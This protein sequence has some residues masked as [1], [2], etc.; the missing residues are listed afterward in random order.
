MNTNTQQPTSSEDLSLN[1]AEHALDWPLEFW[2]ES[3]L[4][5]EDTKFSVMDEACASALGQQ[6]LSVKRDQRL[7]LHQISRGFGVTSV[8][9]AESACAKFQVR[10]AAGGGVYRREVGS[11]VS[12][13]SCAG[14]GG[15]GRSGCVLRA[16][17]G[18]VYVCCKGDLL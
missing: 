4:G 3:D 9:L 8:Q 16:T 13:F 17:S 1:L 7:D 15:L 2:P 12:Y 14:F 11:G 10:K 5:I 18:V 6:E